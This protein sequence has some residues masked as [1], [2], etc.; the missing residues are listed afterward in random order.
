MGQLESLREL[1]TAEPNNKI[2][3]K[4]NMPVLFTLIG[5]LVN[6]EILETL[7]IE[8]VWKLHS[9]MLVHFTLFRACDALAC[10]L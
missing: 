8:F 5:L 10:L 6:L 9:L 1:N 3:I 2:K 4:K 7:H